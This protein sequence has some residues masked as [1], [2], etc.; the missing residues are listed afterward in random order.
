MQHPLG[1]YADVTGVFIADSYNHSIRR[2]DPPQQTMETVIGD[3][4][5][6]EGASSG[7]EDAPKVR[8]NEPTGITKLGE[9]FFAIADTN[10]HRVVVWN[11]ATGKVERMKIDGEK[12]IAPRS[13][14]SDS[15][16]GDKLVGS[17]RI[18]VR[19]PNLIP[20]SP[21]KVN[22]AK[23][24]LKIILPERYHLN[25]QGPSFGRL[26]EGA[27]PKEVLVKEWKR[28]DL[29]KSLKLDLPRLKADTEYTFQGTFYYC[30]ETK[31]AVC[32]IGSVSFPIR[33]DASGT[34]TIDVSL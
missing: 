29:L 3:G 30:L 24:E 2:Y 33:L 14:T 10:N 17:K 26:F 16:V 20:Q 18:N 6:G 7:P 22:Q 13:E 23:T 34:P 4:K 11:R 12:N 27:P 9:G 8:L 32:E 28:E 25:D 31:N 19:L 21:A 15:G 1:L 5:A